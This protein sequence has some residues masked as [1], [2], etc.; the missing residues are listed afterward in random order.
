MP[1]TARAFSITD[2]R[3]IKVHRTSR[4]LAVLVIAIGFAALPA[5][6]IATPDRTTHRVPGKHHAHHGHHAFGTL[7]AAVF[8]PKAAAGNRFE[9]V[10]GQL[11]QER[12]QSDAVKA[13]GAMFVADHT[14]ALQQVAQVAANLG[15]ALPEGLDP[16]QQA[17]VDR[18]RTL[19]GAAFD[20]AWLKAQLHAHHKALRLHLRAA[21]RGE[22]EA[23]RT[24]GQN[25]LPV[26]TR[27]L[28]EL[29]DLAGSARHHHRH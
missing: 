13:L 5:W 27:H 2:R 4:K 6:A 22:D 23:I 11:A 18:L 7:P 15:V 19:S 9:I 8:L 17:I 24:L 12:A 26:I 10:T 16:R 28:G 25:A 3:S 14:A 21:I 1:A 29:I 20:A